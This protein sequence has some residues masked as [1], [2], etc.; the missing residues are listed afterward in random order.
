MCVLELIYFFILQALKNKPHEVHLF[1]GHHGLARTFKTIN[2]WNICKFVIPWALCVWV[3]IWN[4]KKT[5]ENAKFYTSYCWHE[6]LMWCWLVDCQHLET[7]IKNV[8]V[9]ANKN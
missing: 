5:I 7:P 4:I 9:K 1:V 3:Q 6:W 8:N 2:E